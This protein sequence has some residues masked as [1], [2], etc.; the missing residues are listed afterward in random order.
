LNS[1]TQID[2]VALESNDIK[3]SVKWYMDNFNCKIKYQDETWALLYFKNIGLALVTPNHHPPHIAIVDKK[4]EK[5]PSS[6]S[7][8]DG[9]KYIY[10]TDPD[11]NVIEKLS[12][13]SF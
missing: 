3:K 13:K 1:L 6:K 4:I 2:H 11:K 10:V 8:R 5:N 7:H 9:I 12:S